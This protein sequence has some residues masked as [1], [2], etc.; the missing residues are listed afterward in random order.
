[1]DQEEG[2]KLINTLIALPQET[3]TVEF[4]E[5]NQE[6]DRIGQDISALANSATVTNA[7]CAYLVFGVQDKSHEVVGTKFEPNQK[8][9]GNIELELW[10]QQNLNPSV[11]F[12]ID[13]ITYNNKNVVIFSIPPSTTKPVGFKGVEYIRIGSATTELKNHEEKERSIW[14]RNNKFEENI[15]KENLTSLDVPHFLD[16][17]S[18]SKLTK[19]DPSLPIEGVIEKMAQ[20][21]LIK[22]VLPGGDRYDVLNM[23][24]LLFGKDLNE[25]SPLKRKKIRVIPYKG[26][27][28]DQKWQ[29]EREYPSG[30]AVSF[31]EVIAF[32]YEKLPINEEITR[33]FRQEYKMYPESAI[34]EF[35][36][37]AFIH[38][39]LSVHGSGPMVEL[40]DTRIEI[41][42]VGEPLIDVKRFIDHPAL[43]R[44]GNIAS[45]MRQIGICEEAGTGI[46]RALTQIEIFQLPAPKFEVF[47]NSEY[48]FTRA[49]LY[50]HKNFKNMTKE[51]RIRACF[52]HCVLLYVRNERMS[53]ST[54]R[55]RLGISDKQ[56][57]TATNII[58]ETIK[59]GLIKEDE[60]PKT[61][62]PFWVT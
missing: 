47:N 41:T 39:D 55:T 11:N 52:Q 53:N 24:A 54:L 30:Y 26:D 13:E 62:V 31:E 50:A 25:F 22:K 40:F 48:S 58:N 49:T 16:H 27:S 3:V 12:S 10:L 51:E 20:Y 17:T 23:G 15:A 21:E 36:T 1:M 43:T 37:N 14:Q 7:K 28:R 18:F 42:N 19:Q 32:I 57:P 29:Q 46:D 59:N 61:Y 33:T 5:N 8:K 56:Y 34:R 6:P 38:Q 45:M 2:E 44:N 60:K 9:V 4:K 35:I